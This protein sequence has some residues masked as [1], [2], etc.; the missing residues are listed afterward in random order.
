[1]K[2][3]VKTLQQLPQKKSP[4]LQAK[5]ELLRPIAGVVAVVFYASRRE[6]KASLYKPHRPH[7]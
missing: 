2:P 1:M 7:I 4:L 3:L 6:T 5:S